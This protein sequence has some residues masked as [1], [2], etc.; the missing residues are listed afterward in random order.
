ME[1]AATALLVIQAAV[2]ADGWIERAGA[3]CS[4][5]ARAWKSGVEIRV[6]TDA[7]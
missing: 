7:E 4:W 2:Q 1:G 3:A 6:A 5:L